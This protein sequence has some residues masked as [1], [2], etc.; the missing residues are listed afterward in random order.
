MVA[1]KNS[2]K[3]NSS[4]DMTF[5]I[6][7]KRRLQNE[8]IAACLTKQTGNKCF[9]L[10]SI[11]HLSSGNFDQGE[12]SELVFW[13]CHQKDSKKLLA[14]L[15]SYAKDEK[16]ATRIVFFNVPTYFELNKQFILNGVHA[17]F[18]EHDSLDIFLK[19]VRAV[20]D[21]KLWLSREMMTKCIFE[22]SGKDTSSED[23]AGDLT[24]RQIEILAM[25][26]VGFTNEEIADRLFISPHTVKT[27]IYKIF[28]KINVP[29]RVQA[30]LW[31]AK[32]L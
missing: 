24:E 8:L 10:E 23:A 14:E 3:F 22:K 1:P 15:R 32:N 31:A 5:Y 30:S 11:E 2:K 7:G 13:D 26:S 12:R 17:F 9:V 19:G 16:T 18:Y 20:L 21:G 6:V 28:K 29:N 25:I 4:T 27:H